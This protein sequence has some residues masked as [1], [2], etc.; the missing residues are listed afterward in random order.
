MRKPTI[1]R[2]PNGIRVLLIPMK[3]QRTAT[4]LVL[5]ETG[6]KYEER[7]ENGLSHF[8]EHMCFKG[9]DRRPSAELVASELDSLGAEYNAFTGHEYT[10]YY[11]KVSSE[12]LPAALDIVADIY[13]HPRLLE[14]DIER[15]KGVIIGEIDMR[16]D[17]LPSRAAEL[18][19]ELLYGDQPAGWPIAGQR[20]RIPGF[21]REDFLAYRRK[22]YLANSTVVV[23]TGGFNAVKVKKDIAR[24]FSVIPK[25]RKK[26]KRATND[27]HRAGRVLHREKAA[28]QTHIVVG[29]RGLR[30]RHR[31]IPALTVLST[32]L[33]SGLSSRLFKRL[34]GEMGIGY[35]VHAAHDAFTDHGVFA[36]SVG[37][38]N[39]RVLEAV[40][41]IR[42]EF[43]RIRDE[44]VPGEELRKAK[45]ML[46]GK[47]ALG[48]EA[49][50][51][52]AEFYGFQE[53]LRRELRTP[54]EALR[55]ILNVTQKDVRRVAQKLLSPGALYAALVGPSLDLAALEQTLT[56][57]RP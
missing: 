46:R 18:F 33:G 37:S 56:G 27:G 15:E 3:E 52:I 40:S 39:G 24:L 19:M 13:A 35:Y 38:D 47:L 50:D 25:G 8:L 49:S 44:D 20:E 21:S 23:V 51:E 28:D 6:S 7:E 57:P 36:V 55:R 22:H 17:M 41:A 30:A 16:S 45:E 1:T 5:V 2:L 42:D 26:G 34:R 54:D 29:A 12:H 32:I 10:G 53:V 43:D 48:L 9:T 31:D 14:E 11:A 4:V